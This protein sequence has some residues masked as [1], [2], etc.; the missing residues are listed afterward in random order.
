MNHS[1]G[2]RTEMVQGQIGKSLKK[3][4]NH[5]LKWTRL[6]LFIGPD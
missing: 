2:I 1:K 6:V 5:T 4:Q 3:E